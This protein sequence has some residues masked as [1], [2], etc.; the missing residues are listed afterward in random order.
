V[1]L[2]NRFRDP[3][4]VRELAGRIRAAASHRETY[5]FM[6]VCG[7]H[8]Q[9]IA[10]WGLRELLPDHVRLVS[11]PGCPVCVTPGGYIDQAARLA[12]DGD[13]VVATFGDLLRVP[14]DTTS[15]EAARTAGGD[16]RVVYAPTEALALARKL[17]REVV[18]LA[19]GFETTAA[20]NAAAVRAAREANLT[21]LSFYA[22]MRRVPPVL[23][24]L[25][26]DPQ[27]RLDGF[28]LPG[29]VSAV[30]GRGP[31]R[32]LE[33]RGVPGVIVGFEPVDILRGVEAL[34]G[35]VNRGAADVENLYPRAVPEAGNPQ[36]LALFDRVFTAEDAVWR[37]IGEIPGSG[38]GLAQ[39]W[40]DLDA[41][42]RFGLGPLQA[43]M[44]AGCQC[45]PVL[46]GMILPQECPLFA[47]ACTPEHP[48]GPCMVSR[49]GSCAAHYRYRAS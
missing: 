27:V 30:L 20:G 9:A 42:A 37:G 25:V 28:L 2:Q 17:D 16:V 1:Q 38:Y 22:A 24:A 7:T 19:I 43:R 45:A 41:A 23:D 49:E 29:H 5:T 34:L 15:L 8:T 36:A 26:R 14:G 48:V 33:E 35:A 32:F 47:T 18:F 4:L 10:R 3:T 39:D 6:E 40:R 31:Y 11:G 46:K 13:A 44:P 21:G 12:M